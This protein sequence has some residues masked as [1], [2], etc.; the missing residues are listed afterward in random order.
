MVLVVLHPMGTSVG[1]THLTGRRPCR[2]LSAAALG[3]ESGKVA[4]NC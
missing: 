4:V 3:R 2:D 1:A